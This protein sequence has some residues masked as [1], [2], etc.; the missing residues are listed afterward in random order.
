VARLAVRV[1]VAL[2]VAGLGVCAAA[3]AHS[4]V[5]GLDRPRL[6]AGGVVGA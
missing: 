2:A 3:A 5:P 6:L 1:R 4:D